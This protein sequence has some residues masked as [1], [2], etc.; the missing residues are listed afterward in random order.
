MRTVASSNGRVVGAPCSEPDLL[1]VVETYGRT[2]YWHIDLRS[3]AFRFSNDVC[4]AHGM[5]QGYRPES[6]QECIGWYHPDDQ[7]RVSKIFQQAASEGEKITY[8]A[9]LLN[10]KKEVRWVEVYGEAR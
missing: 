3:Q 4:A 2:G 9:R 10:A 8:Q 5:P 6:L 1:R 7:A